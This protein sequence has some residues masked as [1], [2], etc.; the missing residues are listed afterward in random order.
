[1]LAESGAR[2]FEIAAAGDRPVAAA[3]WSVWRYRHAVEA[4]L[5]HAPADARL[6]DIGCGSGNILRHLLEETPIRRVTGLD[7]SRHCLERVRQRLSCEL[8][9]SSILDPEALRPWRERFDVAV[10]GDVLHHLVGPTR[11]ASRER[12]RQ[13][14]VAAL[15][16]VV[17]GGLLV[18]LEPT[19]RPR[20]AAAL[21][22]H[23]KRWSSRLTAR[24]LE[25]G[26]VWANLGPP[27]VSLYDDRQLR[28]LLARAGREAGGAQLLERRTAG[29]GGWGLARC[30][31]RVTL[32]ARRAG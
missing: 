24:R 22:F 28:R 25:L 10:I 6:I 26:A 3:E 15:G 13:A 2:A 11:R 27:V 17:P 7:S 4:L 20:A 30:R 19:F 23:L 32:V 5:R 9:E 14:L 29:V 31:G 8:I 12:A 1:M 21:A 16:L 18:V